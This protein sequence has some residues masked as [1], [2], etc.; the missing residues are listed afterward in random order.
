[1]WAQSTRPRSHS[2]NSADARWLHYR[3]V[4]FLISDSEDEDGYHEDSEASFTDDAPRSMKSREW[5]W[6][7]A[8]KDPLT[9]VKDMRLG[10]STH[11]CKPASPQSLRGRR[12]KDCRQPLQALEQHRS[13]QAS[14]L[15]QEKKNSKKKQRT[16][17]GSVSRKFT[18]NTP[19]A[20]SP[21]RPQQQRPSSA[22]PVVKKHRQVSIFSVSG[23]EKYLQF[24][25]F[26]LL[27]HNPLF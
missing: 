8:P 25:F 14:P 11:P 7:A 23:S 21:A 20:P 13:Q 6:S 26:L 15:A 18:Q 27:F 3:T 19:P 24:L 4:K 16:S 1:M 22:G 2:L 5:P 9:R 10:P 17:L 12:G